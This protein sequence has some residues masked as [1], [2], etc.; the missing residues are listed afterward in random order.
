VKENGAIVPQPVR[1]IVAPKRQRD[2]MAAVL[3]TLEP[4]F[5]EIPQRILDLIPPRADTTEGG[6]AELFEH[7]TT[8][9]FYPVSAAMTSAEITLDALLD[10]RRAA[11]MAQFHAENARNPDFTELVDDVIAVTTRH[12]NGYGGAITRAAA[13][14]VAA[15]LM[16]LANDASADP[17]VRA[18]ATEGLRRL[19]AKLADR[20]VI[21][22]SELAHRHALRDD[23]ERFLTRPDQPRTQPK[24]PEVPMGPPIGN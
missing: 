18:D 11:R 1:R 24:P 4:S 21:D 9:A 19:A 2:A 15:H 8:P 12:E 3:S 6:V 5:M 22:A 13:R 7:R 17:Q 16:T 10:A 23:I 14:S 20:G